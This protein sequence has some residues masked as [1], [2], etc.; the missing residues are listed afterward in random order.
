[1]N[2]VEKHKLKLEQELLVAQKYFFTDEWREIK[3]EIE[4]ELI[5]TEE[6]LQQDN[7]LIP[8]LNHSYN[9]M[10]NHTIVIME[11]YRDRITNPTIQRSINMVVTHNR[12]KFF[13]F[14]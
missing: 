14:P 11:K 5:Q 7:H 10:N 4:T 9:S 1:M 2:D 3:K 12:E 13:H 8:E 6:F